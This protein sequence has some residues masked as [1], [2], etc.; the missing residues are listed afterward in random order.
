[1]RSSS[2]DSLL[3]FISV[4]VTVFMLL[5]VDILMYC[6]VCINPL[7]VCPGAGDPVCR[8][9][10]GGPCSRFP[11]RFAVSVC[12]CVVFTVIVEDSPS[13]PCG[14]VSPGP[15]PTPL[16]PYAQYRL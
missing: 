7:F 8:I 13:F 6:G 1:M 3:F 2:A 14:L 15:V 11:P 10:G 16:V 9:P 4:L 12:V 5:Q